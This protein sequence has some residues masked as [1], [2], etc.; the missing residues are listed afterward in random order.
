MCTAYLKF[1]IEI[2]SS[3]LKLTNEQCLDSCKQKYNL[4]CGL[5]KKRV[6]FNPSVLMDRLFNPY[7]I[8]GSGLMQE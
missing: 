7:C 3:T 4:H 1:R 8:K 6:D 2:N 5:Q